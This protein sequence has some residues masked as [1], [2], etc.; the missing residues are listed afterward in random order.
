MLEDDTVVKG[1][2]AIKYT[3]KF[4]REKNRLNTIA[5]NFQ[6]EVDIT[7]KWELQ[8]ISATEAAIVRQPEK[9]KQEEFLPASIQDVVAANMANILPECTSVIVDPF[10][11]AGTLLREHYLKYP[12]AKLTGVDSS[13]IALQLAKKN[14]GRKCTLKK[15][16]A[17][18]IPVFQNTVDRIVCNPPFNKRV[19][20]TNIQ[21]LYKDFFKEAERIL[22]RKGVLIIYTTQTRLVEEQIQKNKK[23]F[24]IQRIELNLE[25]VSPTV[26]VLEKRIH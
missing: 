15:G 6:I 9:E 7:S 12:F 13:D 8:L 26:F 21:K 3:N 19:R 22:R 25:K 14:I 17:R 1:G 10:C 4:Q 24:L 2:V 5:A 18:N 11:G 23:L 20:I 16:S